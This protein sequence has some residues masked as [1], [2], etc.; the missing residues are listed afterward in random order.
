MTALL[1]RI[2]RPVAAVL[3]VAGIAAAVLVGGGGLDTVVGCGIADDDRPSRTAEDWVTHADHVVVATPTAE[4]DTGRR[5][6]TEGALR[7]ATD[8]TVTFRTDDVLWSAKSPRH[9][10]GENF[11]MVAA[12]WQV[13][14]NGTRTKA[15]TAY[16]PRLETGHTYLLALR[17]A[18][19]R[20]TVLGEGA[21]VPFDDRTVARGEWCGRVLGEENVAR[22]ERFSRTDDRSLEK[23]LAG[24]DGQA[25]KRALDS[26]GAKASAPKP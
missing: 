3:A 17:R 22:G 1:D 18:D 19:D 26:A 13:Y 21:A 25:V 12:G 7:Y 9:S 20:W 11:D 2:G 4:R 24:R 5:D 6:F 14:R 23:L 8:R 16:A 10:L 15:T